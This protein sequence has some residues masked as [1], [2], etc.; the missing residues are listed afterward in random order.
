MTSITPTSLDTL[1]VPHLPGFNLCFPVHFSVWLLQKMFQLRITPPFIN[2]IILS[3][4][5]LISQDG[6]SIGSLSMISFFND[7]IHRTD[8]SSIP[9]QMFAA[10]YIQYWHYAFYWCSSFIFVCYF[11]ISF[12]FDCYYYSLYCEAGIYVCFSGVFV[13]LGKPKFYFVGFPG[14]LER[15]ANNNNN[16]FTAV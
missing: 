6:S 3:F 14:S 5:E 15:W 2:N 12:L 1:L 8:H 11:A 4:P 7:L 10:G 16:N 9:L 13:S